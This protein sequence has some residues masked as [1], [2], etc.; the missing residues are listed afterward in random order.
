[1]EHELRVAFAVQEC[2]RIDELRLANELRVKNHA[3]ARA[4][5]LHPGP[6]FMRE[7]Q[8]RRRDTCAICLG[9]ACDVAMLCCGS[10]THAA[11]TARW[12][13]TGVNGDCAFCRG[14]ATTNA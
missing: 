12:A 10:P 1:M 3:L 13:G 7:L 8:K 11:C 5:A 2:I 4:M 9:A 14:R 6:T